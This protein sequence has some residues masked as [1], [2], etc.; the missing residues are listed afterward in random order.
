MV[1]TVRGG[2]V[3]R[4]QP[5]GPFEENPRVSRTLV[6]LAKR[7][8]NGGASSIMFLPSKNVQFTAYA[9]AYHTG[10][11]KEMNITKAPAG[12]LR[13]TVVINISGHATGGINDRVIGWAEREAAKVGARVGDDVTKWNALT[14][15]AGAASRELQSDYQRTKQSVTIDL[16]AIAPGKS[17]T[18]SRTQFEKLQK[19]TMD[20]D[21]WELAQMGNDALRKQF[22]ATNTYNVR[23]RTPDG[24]TTEMRGIPRNDPNRIE[25]ATRIPVEIP[26]GTKGEVVLEAWPTGSAEVAGYVEA[27]RY[28]IHIGDGMFDMSKAIQNAEAYQARYPQV[29]WGTEHESDDIEKH[30]VNPSPY[31]YQDF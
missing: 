19:A 4:L 29:R 5:T 22:A 21:D 3:Q 8:N 20:G 14:A 13:G 26:D 16:G 23:I 18:L 15:A 2:N 30:H 6:D 10:L 7:A 31:P 12:P 9:F 27:R 1:T 17:V 11:A 25:Y 24:K 28:K